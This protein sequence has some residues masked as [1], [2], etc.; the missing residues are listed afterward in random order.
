MTTFTPF[1]KSVID[2]FNARHIEICRES[3][4]KSMLPALY[5]HRVFKLC[6]TASNKLKKNGSDYWAEVYGELARIHHHNAHN[7]T[8]S[9]LL[10]VGGTRK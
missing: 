4:G 6:K 7:S 5:H 2:T 9:E 8:G 3:E 10:K 1:E